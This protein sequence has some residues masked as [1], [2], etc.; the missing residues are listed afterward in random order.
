MKF[1]W[2]FLLAFTIASPAHAM[3]SVTI[4]AVTQADKNFRRYSLEDD[5]K[6]SHFLSCGI[7]DES[8]VPTNTLEF[9]P[10]N[11]GGKYKIFPKL[12]E[13]DC[14]QY[15]SMVL[16]AK[17]KTPVVFEYRQR[18][19]QP[20]AKTLYEVV[21][22]QKISNQHPIYEL[23]ISDGGT[24]QLSCFGSDGISSLL[25]YSNT[26]DN[27]QSIM[28][29]IDACATLLKD[30]MSIANPATHK[31]GSAANPSHFPI[32]LSIDEHNNP[33]IEN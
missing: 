22:F 32:T 4:I 3:K 31:K 26:V 1:L 8:G 14:A 6:I 17:E 25:L 19:E 11:K 16:A 23:R 24:H 12:S 18:D 20:N 15:E 21:D 13:A 9:Y 2:L 33:I 29:S 30:L 5:N 28:I 27:L 7:T 10:Q